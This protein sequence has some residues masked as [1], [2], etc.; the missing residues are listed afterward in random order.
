MIVND[1]PM[2]SQPIVNL[3]VKEDSYIMIRIT[4]MM[5]WGDT[6]GMK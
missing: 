5:L 4:F 2:V 1:I 3:I 6:T